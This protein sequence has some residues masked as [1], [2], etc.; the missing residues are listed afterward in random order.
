MKS[1]PLALVLLASPPA[2]AQTTSLVS[3][4]WQGGLGDGPCLYPEITPDARFLTCISN[5]TYHVPGE[6]NG[7]SDIFFL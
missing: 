4:D 5:A 1:L 2:L 3:R 7:V 6:A